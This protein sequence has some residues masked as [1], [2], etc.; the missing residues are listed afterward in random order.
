MKQ[1]KHV[2]VDY[3]SCNILMF[4]TTVRHK[5]TQTLSSNNLQMRVNTR[6]AKKEH[7][8]TFMAGHVQSEKS[9]L[10]CT[11]II[12]MRPNCGF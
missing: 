8:L 6:Q 5:A 4:N 2:S 10:H 3:I 9:K 7:G 12:H 11:F 1:H